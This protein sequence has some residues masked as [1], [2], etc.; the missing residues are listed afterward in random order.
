MKNFA[1]TGIRTHDLPTH[2]LLLQL[3]N[4]NSL[5]L[6]FDGSK[7]WE[8]EEDGADRKTKT[9]NSKVENWSDN[10]NVRTT[11]KTILFGEELRSRKISYSGRL[12]LKF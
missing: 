2:V 4:S 9:W 1:G 6:Y 11:A 7:I 10:S 5:F 12:S 3:T 8:I